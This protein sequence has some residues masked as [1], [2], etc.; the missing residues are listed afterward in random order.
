M[1]PRGAVSVRSLLVA[2]L[3]ALACVLAGCETQ[4]RLYAWPDYEASVHAVCTDFETSDLPKHLERF[5]KEVHAIE[6]E[7]KRLPPGVH[8]HLGYLYAEAGDRANARRE[9][10]EERRLFPESAVFVT[11]LLARMQP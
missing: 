5:A 9:F 6:A 2:V 11:R 1:A 10:E 8:A 3:A 4:K 7:G